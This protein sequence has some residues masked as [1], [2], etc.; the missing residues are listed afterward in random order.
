MLESSE[1]M[2]ILAIRSRSLVAGVSIVYL[3][4]TSNT[5]ASTVTA[6]LVAGQSALTSALVAGN[7]AVSG[8]SSGVVGT[9]TATPTAF[10]TRGPTK[11]IA[12]G[13]IAAAVILSVFG[14][15]MIILA[16]MYFFVW[17]K[18]SVPGGNGNTA[19]ANNDPISPS[20]VILQQIKGGGT[21]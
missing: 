13:S 10:P 15:V 5:D 19:T 21:V 8:T 14:G 7:Y 2:N 3:I 11:Y 20:P 18:P 17:R 6:Q 4:T 9:P 16:S 1:N 12:A